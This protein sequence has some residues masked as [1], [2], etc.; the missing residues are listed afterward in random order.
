VFVMLQA[1]GVEYRRYAVVV[2]RLE[3]LDRARQATQFG[4]NRTNLYR[5]NVPNGQYSNTDT[6]IAPTSSAASNASAPLLLGPP[7]K[8]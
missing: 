1:V 5:T 8:K 7:S 3:A 6:P 4:A 2:A